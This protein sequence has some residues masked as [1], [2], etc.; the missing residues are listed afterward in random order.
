MTSDAES[1]ILGVN[2]VQ[3]PIPSGGE[4]EARAFYVGVLGL[5][6]I[7]KPPDL[8]KRGGLWCVAPDGFEVHLGAEHAFDLG[9]T[10]RHV[11]F[12][13]R[14]LDALR[15]RLEGAG[16]AFRAEGA[17]GEIPGV[18]R[19]QAFDPFGNLLEFQERPE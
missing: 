10:R 6:E 9:S 19:F 15:A 12:T 1:S 11:G 8:A 18:R 14:G 13:A 17:T 5:R 16:C 3:I 4:D 7:R 2:H